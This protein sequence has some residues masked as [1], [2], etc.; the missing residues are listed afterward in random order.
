MLTIDEFRIVRRF[1]ITS[2]AATLVVTAGCSFSYSSESSSDSSKSSSESSSSPFESSS[3]SSSGDE[4]KVEDYEEDV[5]AYT[6]EYVVAGGSPA[7][8]LNG[9]GDLAR[10][11]G[12]S[13]WESDRATWVGIGA[14]LAK[15]DIKGEGVAAYKAEWSN[16]DAEAMSGIQR[17]YDA[18]R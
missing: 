16:G 17:G 12:V 15:A 18:K 13:D 7:A 10:K 8:F 6:S 9:I 3:D 11:R 4:A 2:L 5:A 1:A 14:G